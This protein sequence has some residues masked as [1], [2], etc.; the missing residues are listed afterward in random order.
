MPQVVMLLVSAITLAV[1]PVS[2][3]TFPHGISFA[4]PAGWHV[5]SAR[6]N[7][8]RDPVT[9]FTA[10]SGAPTA[11]PARAASYAKLS[12]QEAPEPGLRTD[13]FAHRWGARR[14]RQCRRENGLLSRLCR[15]SPAYVRVLTG[16]Q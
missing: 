1:A 4:I 11:N 8:V 16:S 15:F 13:K 12:V 7:G 10:T 6:I 9:V 3:I 5:T 14:P 2:H